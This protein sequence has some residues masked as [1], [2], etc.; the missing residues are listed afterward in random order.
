MKRKHNFP[1]ATIVIALVMASVTYAYIFGPPSYKHYYGFINHPYAPIT[2]DDFNGDGFPDIAWCDH[3]YDSCRILL[4]YGDGTFEP[5]DA[6][7]VS[8][9][10]TEI[11][12]GDFTSDGIIDLVILDVTGTDSVYVLTIWMLGI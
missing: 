4:G 12:T 9:Y 2:T 7:Y 1:R 6:F 3:C 11:V 10:P 5:L 8:I